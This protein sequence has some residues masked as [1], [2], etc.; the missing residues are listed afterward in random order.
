MYELLQTHVQIEID[1]V[2][3]FF[4]SNFSLGRA[5]AYFSTAKIECSFYKL[6]PKNA[7]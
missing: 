1:F 5:Y 7:H 3:A 4:S 6:W 2:I